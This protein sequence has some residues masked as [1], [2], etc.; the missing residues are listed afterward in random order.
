VRWFGAWKIQK[1]NCSLWQA[2]QIAETASG[3]VFLLLPT[4]PNHLPLYFMK[5]SF[6]LSL[7]LVFCSVSCAF[8]QTLPELEIPV[9]SKNYYEICQQLD[10]YFAEEYDADSEECADNAQVK[11]ERW[12]WWW[13]D[14]VKADGSFPDL[15]AQWLDYQRNFATAAAARSNQPLWEN[16]GPTHSPNYQ[17]NGSYWGVGRTKHVAFHPQDPLTFFVGATCGGIWKTSDG[18]FTWSPMGDGLP[19]LP[20]SII[21][22][23]PQH[24]D[25]MYISLGDKE[26]WWNWNLGVYKSTDGGSTWS[27]TG[28]DW[29]LSD[30]HVIY[31]LILS[32]TDP[33][34]LFAATNKGIRRS[35]DGG[36]SWQTLKTGEF[37]DIKFQPDNDSVLYA[38]QHN[39]WGKSQLVKSLDN[40]ATWAQI[41]DFQETQN[42]IRIAVSPLMPHWVGLHFTQGKR[43][44]I[45]KNGGQNFENYA[46]P[47]DD[48]G[49]FCFSPSDTNIVYLGGVS[50]SRSLDQGATWEKI[51]HWYNDGIHAEV[52]A[53][54]RDLVFNPHN[55]QEVWYCN[56]GGLYRYDEASQTWMDFSGG[57]GI[58]QFYR[59]AVSETGSQLKIAAGSQDNGGWLRI[60][61]TWKH[62]NGGDAMCQIIDP[63]NSNIIYTEYY[64]GNDIYRSFN[65][66]NTDVN[67]ADNIPDNPSGDWVTPFMLNPQNNKTFL[68]AFHDLYRSFDRGNT[69]HK[70]SENLTSSVDNKIRD[71]TMAPSDTNVILA[72]RQNR[73]Y[74][75][76]NGGQAWTAKTISTNEEITRVAIHPT[77]PQRMWL[78]KGGY[79][80]GRKVYATT[81]G[82]LTHQNLSGELPNVPVNC[83]IYDAPTNYLIVGTDIGVFY[84]DAD[85]IDWQPYGTGMPAVYVLDL[86]VRQATRK[87][88]A[89]THGRGVYSVDL[90]TLVPT[91]E[92]T[93]GP[94]PTLVFP[95]PA[96]NVLLFKTENEAVFDGE[97]ELF[98]AMGRRVLRKKIAQQILREVVL[99]VAALPTG[100][101]A[102]RLRDA[103]GHTLAR[104]KVVLER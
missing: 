64:G 7:A 101:Y 15:R 13:R 14:R 57:L 35:L 5:K 42:E 19:Y 102:L 12:K 16:E 44:L 93:A 69:F 6:F 86:K 55:P 22:I 103:S 43:F 76:V 98:D 75:T 18:G 26:G 10:A 52:H 56:D 27:P 46:A 58:A 1:K 3:S 23:D 41:S 34:R 48:W 61:D 92:P 50:M 9:T 89:G 66:Y 68:V 95:N 17:P 39:Y 31:N 78:T 97:I 29:E 11:Y 62:T 79:A 38:A 45:S 33:Q 91:N 81:N 32:P 21:L 65:N 2:A 80:D 40:G 73:I 25:T 30:E 53:D 104:E 28:L 63:L 96:R 54:A 83:I 99:D 20:V 47:D 85:Q 72:A 70:I 8:A 82:W 49:I 84:S 90:E 71:F 88:Y 87:L 77:D 74:K 4:I 60:G 94:N 100:V 67:I 51:T 24:P 36:G 37:T 59:I